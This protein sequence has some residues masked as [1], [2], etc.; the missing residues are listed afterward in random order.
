MNN[1]F[2]QNTLNAIVF[3]L[4]MILLIME[5]VEKLERSYYSLNYWDRHQSYSPYCSYGKVAE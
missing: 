5:G 4:Q 1:I 2:K 3:K